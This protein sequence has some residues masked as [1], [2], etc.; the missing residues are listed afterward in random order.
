MSEEYAAPPWGEVGQEFLSQY[1][2]YRKIAV[3]IPD[4][5]KEIYALRPLLHCPQCKAERT[6]YLAQVASED[7]ERLAQRNVLG[8]YLP[9]GIRDL[10]YGCTKCEERLY[11]AVRFEKLSASKVGQWP[12]WSIAISSTME[13]FLGEELASLYLRGKIL[14]SQGYGIGAFGYYRRIVEHLIDKLLTAIGENIEE[15]KTEKFS[16]ALEASRRETVAQRKIEIVKD[17]LPDSLRPDGLNPLDILHGSLSSGLHEGAEDACLE[18]GA[19][20]RN[21]LEYLVAQLALRRVSRK[22]FTDSMRK[23]LAA[24]SKGSEK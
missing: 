22:S 20:I 17:M 4:D 23:L 10:S 1:P 12:S 11:F 24:R 5:V 2:L 14:E 18:E 13:F 6:F 8:T 19:A 3:E 9:P 7:L 16:A 21:A 15:A